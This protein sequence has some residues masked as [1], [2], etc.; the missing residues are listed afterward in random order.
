[1][2]GLDG[3]FYRITADG[4]AHPV[5]GT[6]KTPFAAVSYFDRDRK[7][8][9]DKEMTFPELLKYL[10]SLL[11]SPNIFYA[12]RI[13]GD[14]GYIKTRSVP[15]QSRPYP[16][17]TEVVAGQPTFDLK[18]IK[19]SLVGFRCPYYVKGVNVPGYHFHFIDSAKTKGGHVLDLR[20]GRVSVAIAPTREFC[21]S[22]PLNPVFDAT[23]YEHQGE[24]KARDVE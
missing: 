13:E 12:I 14:F 16:K 11:P 21:L 8:A 10:D 5:Q 23:D 3:R 18:E 20:L 4:T 1:M 6:W 7:A 24:L 9:I 19:G 15:R 17:L 2:I 22:L